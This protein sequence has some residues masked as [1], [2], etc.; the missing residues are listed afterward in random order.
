MNNI[1]KKIVA[2]AMVVGMVTMIAPSAQALTAAELQTQIDAL[3]AQIA[4][5]QAQI[6][7]MGGTSTAVPAA[8]SG[9]TFSRNLTLTMTGT[10][11]KCLQAILNQD[12][13]TQ[14]A[15]SGVGSAGSETTYFGPL[16]KAAVVKYR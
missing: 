14:V 3:L 7:A 15:A 10:D 2:I 1:T 6:T 5:L 9:I 4:T 12:A 16:T 13:A 11:V 8:C